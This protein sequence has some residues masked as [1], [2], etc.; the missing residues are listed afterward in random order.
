MIYRRIVGL[1]PA[2]ADKIEELACEKYGYEFF[3]DPISDARFKQEMLISR[4]WYKKQ[5]LETVGGITHHRHLEDDVVEIYKCIA[6]DEVLEAIFSTLKPFVLKTSE[7]GFYM[8]DCIEVNDNRTPLALQL[9]D[10]F[11]ETRLRYPEGNAQ[12]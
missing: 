11:N 5:L 9:E 4:L 1:W 3:D 2:L 8:V 10:Y 7:E 6:G 12:L